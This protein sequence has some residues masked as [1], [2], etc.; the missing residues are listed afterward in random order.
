MRFDVLWQFF[1]EDYELSWTPYQVHMWIVVPALG[2]IGLLGN[3]LTLL[4]FSK[5]WAAARS[6]C[7][8]VSVCVRWTGQQCEGSMRDSVDMLEQQK[9]SSCMHITARLESRSLFSL[10]DVMAP[11]NLS[12]PAGKCRFECIPC[13]R[14]KKGVEVVERGSLAGMMALAVSDLFFCLITTA[15]SFV[16]STDL[17]YESKNLSLYLTMYGNYFQNLF[18]KLSTHVTVVM[19]VYRYT[20]LSHPTLVRNHLGNLL[21]YKLMG[22]AVG[23]AFWV[24]FMLPL[25]WKWEA[26]GLSC[27]NGLDTFIFLTSGV[28]VENSTAYDVF[29][30]LWSIFGFIFPMAILIFCNTGIILA[31]RRS[32]QR[33]R[34]QTPRNLRN[35]AQRKTNITL[36]CIIVAFF[37]LVAPSESVDF[38]LKVAH[39]Y[40]L[41]WFVVVTFFNVLL[42]VNM[43]FNFALYCAVNSQ[44]RKT[45]PL[46]YCVV[47]GRRC[48]ALLGACRRRCGGGGE[49]EPRPPGTSPAG[50]SPPHASTQKTCMETIE[51]L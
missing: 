10:V 15:E 27:K 47:G 26:V 5:R 24:V 38:Y 32:K 51:N 1:H 39:K 31:I 18:V 48:D 35:N 19:A 4:V 14:L 7:A 25:A 50:S 6:L 42:M 20:A 11:C 46:L 23:V 22:I 21:R 3:T 17:L 28:F 9:H 8:R 16:D 29:S 12:M 2:I 33:M 41:Q 44:F 40:S 36:T 13:C 30:Y 45:I 34:S 43:S 37:L 49:Q